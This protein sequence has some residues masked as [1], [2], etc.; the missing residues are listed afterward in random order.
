MAPLRTTFSYSQTSVSSL[1]G[2]A[3]QALVPQSSPTLVPAALG[4]LSSAT[5]TGLAPLRQAGCQFHNR[6]QTHFRLAGRGLKTGD[7][8]RNHTL[9]AIG[10]RLGHR[11]NVS[12]RATETGLFIG[13]TSAESWCQLHLRAEDS[14]LIVSSPRLYSRGLVVSST[15]G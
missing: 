1:G 2:I 12:Q 4:R 11:S 13:L 14:S 9:A 5:T 6:M 15:P 3:R 10:L 8:L 7:Q